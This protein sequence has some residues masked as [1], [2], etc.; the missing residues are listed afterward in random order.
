MAYEHLCQIAID[1]VNCEDG[2]PT[3]NAFANRINDMCGNGQLTNAQYN[4]LIR[5]V[6]DLI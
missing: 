4:H 2:A 1:I 3:P 6:E 5:Y